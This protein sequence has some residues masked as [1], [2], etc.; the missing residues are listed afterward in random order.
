MPVDSFWWPLD[1]SARA[2]AAMEELRER[3]RHAPVPL[4]SPAVA[5]VS[6]Q[7][8]R[9]M[10]R[11]VGD[12]M[13]RDGLPHQCHVIN[14]WGDAR[15]RGHPLMDHMGGFV[16]RDPR[17]R[18]FILQVD[19]EGDFH[20]WQSLAYA[21]MAGVD[22]DRP[23]PPAGATLRDLAKNSRYLNTRDGHELG[24][25]LFALAHLDPAIDGRPFLLA[26]EP[27]GVPRL[28]EMAVEAHHY[29][30][31]EVC[32]KFHLTE[33]LCAMASR[34]EGLAA[35]RADAQGFLT[36]QLDMLL[37]LSLILREAR[38]QIAAGEPPREESLLQELRDALVM[39]NYLE[40]HCY[41]AGHLV[42][43]ATFAE[44]LGFDLAPEHRSAMAL[45]VNDL[46]ALLPGYLPHLAFADCFLHL[47][48]YR[49]A[50]TLMVE[51]ERVRAEGRAATRDD[52][53]RYAVDFD[54]LPPGLAPTPRPEDAGVF[55]LAVAAS[56]PRQEFLRILDAYASLAPDGLEARG[57]FDHF[58]RMG[59]P[60]WPRSFHYELLDYGGPVGAEIHLETDA[61]RPLAGRVRALR[62]RVARRFPGRPVEWD[63]AWSRDRGRLYVLF[64][65]DQAPEEVAAGLRALIDET[66]PELDEA[67]SRILMDPGAPGA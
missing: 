45:V 44:I 13:E 19:P 43:L 52:L 12:I 5:E 23:I 20:P 6:D 10:A 54:A 29:G 36:G 26:G 27:C 65:A 55:N 58:R 22:P 30:S 2:E 59:P 49:R 3:L 39:G 60:T 66:F 42:E 41:Y 35:Y 67:A 4:D 11:H 28:M 18:A 64:P 16:H 17:G 53:A 63:P 24:H 34:V 46:N 21:V 9:L 51:L 7:L 50:A 32:R 31:F 15:F 56:A 33:G 8:S 57:K 48:H 47:G 25:L 38:R 1:L 61:V 37:I 62:D 14:G 40:N